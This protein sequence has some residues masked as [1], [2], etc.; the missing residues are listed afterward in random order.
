MRKVY[1]VSII[2]V[3]KAEVFS[4]KT[5]LKFMQYE[6][7]QLNSPSIPRLHMQ[8]DTAKFYIK[9]KFDWKEDDTGQSDNFENLH[10]V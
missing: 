5:L 7:K 1:P 3:R 9:T 4:G 8:L 10:K 2:G 6:P